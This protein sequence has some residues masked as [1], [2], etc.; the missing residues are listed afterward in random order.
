VLFSYSPDGFQDNWLHDALVAMLAGDFDRIDA[1]QPPQSWPDCIPADHRATL[2]SR[3]GLRA[4]RQ[5]LLDA[6][7]ALG[8]AQRTSVR[9]AMARQ[10]EL[11]AMLG[12]GLSC[13]RLNQLPE[14]IR[15][16][17]KDMFEFAFRLLTDFGLRDRNYERIY[18]ALS[19]KICAFCGVEI[20]DAPGQKREP[21]DHYLPIALY[22]FAGTNFRNLAPM[23][24]KCNSRYK[25]QQDIISDAAGN[26]RSCCDPYD[27]PPITLS[28]SGSRPF[29]GELVN[30]IRCPEWVIQWEGGDQ[31]KLQTWE[32]V[33][34]ISERYR[35]SSLNPNFRDWIDHF[36]Q[37]AAWKAQPVDT[38]AGVRDALLEF[39]EI[40]VP[41]G[42][43]DSAFLKRATMRMLAHRCDESEEG[44]RLVEW[45][46]GLIDEA[47]RLRDLAA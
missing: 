45:L 3:P 18:D 39:A 11:P 38:C 28:L 10:N 22:P 37:W 2:E 16:P 9:G 17:I 24:N 35:A 36:G 32:N 29:E 46:C 33:F 6:Y 40:V 14:A 42:L 41:E 26:R 20:L 21:L 5:T 1:G 15:M 23:G 47:R 44:A 12:D 7:E 8:N 27:S 31:S 30:L 19:Y 13:I 25:L 34:D 43:A 4:R